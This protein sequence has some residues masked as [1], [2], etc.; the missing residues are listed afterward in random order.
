MIFSSFPNTGSCTLETPLPIAIDKEQVKGPRHGLPGGL[1]I[2]AGPEQAK[3]PGKQPAAKARPAASQSISVAKAPVLPLSSKAAAAE[4]THIAEPH[5]SGGVFAQVDQNQQHGKAPPKVAVEVP[6]AS[7][8]HSATTPAPMEP[9]PAAHQGSAVATSYTTIGRQVIEHV[10][11]EVAVTVTAGTPEASMAH[12][13]R[14]HK[15]HAARGHG[16]GDRRLR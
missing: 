12:Y 4:S 5:G 3:K 13:K 6:S 2:Q 11:V 15:H 1:K 8:S 16:I 7:A 10:K 14:H 9:A